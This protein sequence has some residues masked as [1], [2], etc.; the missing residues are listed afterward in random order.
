MNYTREFSGSVFMNNYGTHFWILIQ[1]SSFRDLEDAYD[2]MSDWT[3]SSLPKD[4]LKMSANSWAVRCGTCCLWVIFWVV[5]INW[6]WPDLHG[7]SPW[8]WQWPDLQV[9]IEM[10]RSSSSWWDDQIFKFMV[11]WPDLQVNGEMT[12]SSSSWCDDQIFMVVMTS[13]THDVLPCCSTWRKWP[14]WHWWLPGWKWSA[15]LALQN[16]FRDLLST[17]AVTWVSYLI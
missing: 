9:L 5:I 4:N 7:R 11:S 14:S 12:W 13:G 15:I 10:T 2:I 1:H 17:A 16:Q 8:W 6:W 3:L